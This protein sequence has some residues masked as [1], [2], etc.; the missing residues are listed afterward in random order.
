MKKLFLCVLLNMGLPAMYAQTALTKAEAVRLA[1]DS[2]SKVLMA[3]NG[4]KTA[5]AKFKQTDAVFLPQL[6]LNYSGMVTNNPLNAF[7]FKLQERSISQTDFAPDLLNHPKATG[8]FSTQAL[9]MQ[10]IFNADMLAM[11]E[12]ARKHIAIAGYQ[13]QRTIDYLKFS[14]ETEYNQLQLSYEMIAVS[15]EALAT[16]QAIYHWT[17]DRYDQGYVQKSDLLNVD[18]NVKSAETQLAAA[19]AAV[20]EHSDNLSV[21]MG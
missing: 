1:A 21:L 17:K 15:K 18:V 6:S 9:W 10:P 11:R 12:A 20:Q 2:S 8:N 7:G 4:I 3:D 19:N 14:A 13:K 5:E 16:L